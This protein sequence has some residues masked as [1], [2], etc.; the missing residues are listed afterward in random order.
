M[1]LELCSG[2]H[3]RSLSW[4][5][6]KQRTL[7]YIT[8]RSNQTTVIKEHSYQLTESEEIIIVKT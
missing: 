5:R 4:F 3:E 7:H 2:T 6:I 8:S 1:E